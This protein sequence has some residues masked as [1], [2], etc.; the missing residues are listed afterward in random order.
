MET[1]VKGSLQFLVPE[2]RMDP[3]APVPIRS[4]N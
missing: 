1:S 4:E 2:G 3:P